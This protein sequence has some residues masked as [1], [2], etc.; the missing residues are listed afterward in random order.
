MQ[1]MEEERKLRKLKEAIW[2]VVH[3]F[4]LFDRS[5]IFIVIYLST[6]FLSLLFVFVRY[7]Q[8]LPIFEH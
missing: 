8:S 4:L 6:S 5:E 3:G 7:V 1:E 2:Y